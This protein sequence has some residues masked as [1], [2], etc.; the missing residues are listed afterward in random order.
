LESNDEFMRIEEIAQAL[1]GRLDG[2]GAIEISR[3]VHPAR[4][5]FPSDLALALSADAAAALSHSKAQAAVISAKNSVSPDNLRASIAV[6]EARI[7]I[8]KL[9]ALFDAG[10]AHE[11]GIHPTAVIV[12]DA[13]LG[14]GVSVGAYS[15]VGARSRIGVGTIVM[16][17][18]TIGADVVIGAR[19]LFHSGVRIGDRVAIGDRVIVHANAVIGADG[20]SFAPN[21]LS[22]MRFGPD[23]VVTR[24]HSLGNVAIGDDV[25]IGACTAIDRSTLETTRI[26]RGSKIDNHCHIGHNVIIGESCV[27]AG[28]IGVSGSVVIGNRVRIAGGVGIGDHVRIGDEAVIGPGSGIATNVEAGA[29]LLGYPAVPQKRFFEQLVYTSRQKRLHQRVDELVSRMDALEATSKK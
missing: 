20:F 6:T 24:I 26:G 22:A 23:V 12:T 21:L 13:V 18:V 8:A 5:E 9:T 16:P 14:E 15:V 7:A 25:E 27:L 28:M 4:A 2:D 11:R 3:V 10:P 17:H 1:G 29:F 19:G